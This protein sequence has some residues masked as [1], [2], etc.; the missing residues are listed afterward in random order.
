MIAI[1]YGYDYDDDYDYDYDYDYLFVI[2]CTVLH[3]FYGHL[4]TKPRN[5][6]RTTAAKR[7]T[8]SQS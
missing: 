8:F 3:V 1:D 2:Q 5:L 4:Y 7:V 6:Q